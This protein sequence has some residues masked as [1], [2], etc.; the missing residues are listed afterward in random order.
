MEVFSK[1]NAINDENSNKTYRLSE[2]NTE[3]FVQNMDK[4]SGETNF[5]VGTDQGNLS[6][7]DYG[8]AEIIMTTNLP[9]AQDSPISGL[10]S[11]P[12]S[13]SSLFLVLFV[14]FF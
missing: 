13:Q 12:S 9:Y 10:S 6:I 3:G 2:L 11:H 4:L 8:S 14:T 5:I 7:Y 1:Q